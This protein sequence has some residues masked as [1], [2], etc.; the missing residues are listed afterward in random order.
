MKLLFYVCLSSLFVGLISCQ[1][2]KKAENENLDSL[3]TQRE[4][5]KLVVEYRML[6]NVKYPEDRNCI[7]KFASNKDPK[8]GMLFLFPKNISEFGVD[9][10]YQ[11]D[12]YFI[13]EIGIF[14]KPISNED[15]NYIIYIMTFDYMV[16]LVVFEDKKT[17]N[18]YFTITGTAKGIFWINNSYWVVGNGC[19]M[20]CS[21]SIERIKDPK[22]LKP[23][24][25]QN[26][27]SLRRQV[28]RLPH[29]EIMK[30]VRQESDELLFSAN[31]TLYNGIS[32]KLAAFI[33]YQN[34]MILVFEQYK[35]NK[36]RFIQV[37]EDKSVEHI[38]S[39]INGK[40]DTREFSEDDMTTILPKNQ[41]LISFCQT[42]FKIENDTLFVYSL[43]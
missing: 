28:R 9:T 36:Y 43:R 34:S 33:P 37:N 39:L 41:S 38:D 23:T 21:M 14:N 1:N 20:G 11:E 25:E 6:S 12:S 3:S 26:L 22:L 27:D 2:N 19:H 42:I 35:S 32:K 29:E 31:D 40:F 17:K 5:S 30:I 15:K 24:N 8:A 13:S 16:S 7:E 10:V 4:K 18:R